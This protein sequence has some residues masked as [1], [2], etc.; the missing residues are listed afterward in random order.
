MISTSKVSKRARPLLGTIVEIGVQDTHEEIAQQIISDAFAQIERIQRLMSRFD[1][2][3][4]VTQVN[5]L[6]VNVELVVSSDLWTVLELAQ[7]ISRRSEGVFSICTEADPNG[8]LLRLLDDGRVLRL[9]TGLIDLGGIAKGYAVDQAIEFIRGRGTES[10]YVNAGGDVRAF[11]APYPILVRNP[12][13]PHESVASLDLF[14]A[15]FATSAA[16]HQHAEYNQS[17][18][19]VDPRSNK[20]IPSGASASVMASTCVVADALTKCMLMM[21]E[22]VELLLNQ[23]NAC[24]FLVRGEHLT[25]F[26]KTMDVMPNDAN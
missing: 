17:G 3:S 14:N 12:L 19:I 20:S 10:A 23:F 7:D 18:I 1:D 22:E 11:G 24:G 15:A 9:K 6:G 5:R 26:P 16:Y 21:E 8:D 4:E 2:S 13:R 25:S